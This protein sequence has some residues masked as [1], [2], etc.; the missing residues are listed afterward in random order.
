MA[1]S[2]SPL[3]TRAG[4]RVLEQGGN[5]VDAAVAMAGMLALA[6]PMMSGLGGDT[7]VL[8]WSAKEQ[9]VFGLNSSG[10]APS[11]ASLDRIGSVPVMPEHGAATVTIPGA[12]D[13][14]CALL[15][16]FGDGRHSVLLG[17]QGCW[18]GIDVPGEA[19]Q[20][21]VIDKLPFPTPTDPLTQARVRQV[22]DRGGRAF[23]ECFLAEAA[24]SLKQGAG[25]LIRTER[26]RGLLVVCDPRLV[27]MPYGRRLRA[28]VPPMATIESKEDAL[29]WLSVLAGSSQERLDTPF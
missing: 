18:E 13:G 29:E 16:R 3:V 6:E 27:T 7:M 24:V 4:L 8:V 20:C 5:A 2:S 15:E 21:V 1:S 14:W 9:K 19:L 28:A 11:G 12:V 26:D 25:R 17:S 10:R 22:E 23:E